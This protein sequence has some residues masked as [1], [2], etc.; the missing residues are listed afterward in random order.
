MDIK[1][2]I[3]AWHLVARE[4]LIVLGG[5]ALAAFVISRFPRFQKFVQDNSIT[6]KDSS[7]NI[8]F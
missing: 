1:K 4:G 8:I 5:I 7:G 3:P 6:L 2:V